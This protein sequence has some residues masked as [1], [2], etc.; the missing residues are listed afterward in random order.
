MN[1]ISE[2][3]IIL[4]KAGY[5]TKYADDNNDILYFEDES[6]LGFV[7]VYPTIKKLIANWKDHQDAFLSANASKLRASVEKHGIFIRFI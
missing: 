3:S 1:I 6:L 4:D 5:K 2:V 7:A